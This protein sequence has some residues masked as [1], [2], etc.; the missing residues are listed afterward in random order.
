MNFIASDNLAP[1]VEKLNCIN[2]RIIGV[3]LKLE[4]GISLLQVYA[5]QQGRTT[6]E[7]EE[8]YRQ[9]KETVDDENTKRTS[10]YVEIGTVIQDVAEEVMIII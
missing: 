5:P 4:T 10:F 2:E 6:V 1:S 3:D 9:I 8:F 7:K